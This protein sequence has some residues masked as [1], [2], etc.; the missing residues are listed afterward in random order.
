MSNAFSDASHV[1]SYVLKS[2]FYLPLSTIIRRWMRSLVSL[3]FSF[4]CLD[5]DLYLVIISTTHPPLPLPHFSSAVYPLFTFSLIVLYFLI[6]CSCHI[7][8]RFIHLFR[9]SMP[10]I[11]P[12]MY[13]GI[14]FS[15]IHNTK[16]RLVNMIMQATFSKFQLVYNETSTS[17]AV[18]TSRSPE[19]L[20]CMS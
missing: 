13:G 12:L 4:V 11:D 8:R 20:A 16:N 10:F 5:F 18:Q 6:T 19:T 9:H 2:S 3:V 15:P 7:S 17:A 14:I 1:L